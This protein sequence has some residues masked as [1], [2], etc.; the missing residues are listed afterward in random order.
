MLLKA[1]IFMK[2]SGG[3]LAHAGKTDR[4]LILL[5]D[6][7]QIPL[8]LVFTRF[9]NLFSAVIPDLYPDRQSTA[10]GMA[11]RVIVLILAMAGVGRTIAVFN[12]FTYE[13][14]KKAA[15]VED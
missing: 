3:A 4:K 1:G 14:M 13:P 6:F 9:L 5:M 11:L 8:S 2:N 10:G 7:L 15:A 12:H